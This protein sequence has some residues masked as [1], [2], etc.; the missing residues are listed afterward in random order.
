MAREHDLKVQLFE[1]RRPE[2]ARGR[3]DACGVGLALGADGQMHVGR[4][5]L[6]LGNL[7]V[8]GCRDHAAYALAIAERRLP[9]THSHSTTDGKYQEKLAKSPAAFWLAEGDQSLI[10]AVRALQA[11][12]TACRADERAA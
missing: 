3:R 10:H 9:H 8:E 11:G 12:A 4:R 6:D 2:Q 5:L 7:T 1:R